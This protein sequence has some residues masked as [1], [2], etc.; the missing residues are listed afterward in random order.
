MIRLHRFESPPEGGASGPELAPVPAVTVDIRIFR[1]EARLHLPPAVSLF[2][3]GNGTARPNRLRWRLRGELFCDE[4]VLVYGRPLVWTGERSRTDPDLPHVEGI[5][6]RTFRLDADH[7][8]LLTAVPRV[9][10]PESAMRVGWNYG[11]VLVRGDD[12]PWAA[13]GWVHIHRHP[14]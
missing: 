1:G 12:P 2:L 8:E 11:A 7:P 9:E 3:P 13:S 6:E 5:F 4:M 14:H 10:F